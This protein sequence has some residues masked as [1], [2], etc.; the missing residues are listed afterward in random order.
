MKI[1]KDKTKSWSIFLSFILLFILSIKPAFGQIVIKEDSVSIPTYLVGKPDPM[2]RFYEHANHQGVQR[3][4]YPYP[5]NDNLTN[6][7]KDKK[8]FIISISNKYI[9]V[10]ISPE[11]GGR[12]FYA[13]DKSNGY[14]WIYR[15]H[16]IK[17]SLIGMEGWWISGGLSWG[18]PHHH[19]P[20]IC[21]PMNYK[22][23]NNPDSSVTVWFDNIDELARMRALVGYTIYPNS[24][25]I[26]MS[27]RLWNKTAITN[28]FLFWTVP[29]VHADTNYQVIFPPS[30]QY[31]TFHGKSWMTT[32]PIADGMFNGYDFKETD[33][34][35]WKN[36]YIPSSFFAWDE[37]ENYFGG[38]NHGLKAGTV[39][40]G[41]HYTQPGMKY[42]AD[43]NN[44]AGRSINSR[45][46]DDD[47][48]YIEQMSGVFTDN[49]PD[50]S[51]LQPY[52]TKNES[53]IWFPIRD[54]DGLKYANND[55]ALNLELSEKNIVKIRMNTASPFNQA[56]VVLKSKGQTI[57]EKD[58]NVS[59]AN[60]YKV[61]VP[62]KAG[63][64]EDDLNITL[65][66]A[67]GNS[68]LSYSPAE[69]HPPQYAK[70]E[71]NKHSLRPEEIKTVE[72]LYMEGLW[73]YQFHSINDPV[74]YF[75]EALKRDPGNY[76][77][78][79][80]LGIMDIQNFKWDEAASHLRKA[81]DRA[82]AHYMRPRD[83]ETVYYLGVV[84]K[85]KGQIDS[86]Y[87]CFYNAIWSYA[88]AAA[89]YLQL[90]QIDCMRG[91][92]DTALDHVNRSL[93]TNTNNVDAINLKTVILRKLNKVSEAKEVAL[94]SLKSDCL[95]RQALNELSVLYANDNAVEASKYMNEFTRIMI[96]SV[97]SYLELATDYAQ[98]G[99]YKDAISVLSIIE[100]K[101]NN[102]PMLYYYLGYYSS[103]VGDQNKAL[104]YYQVASTKP[105]LY[106]F[107][108]R[109]ESIEV[110][111]SV[112]QMN[113]K[114]AKAPYYLGNLLYEHQ[115]ENAIKE[116]EKSRQLDD[117]F[118]IVHRNLGVAYQEVQN[119]Y[120]KALA[121]MEKAVGCNVEN[122]RLLFEID[123][124]NALN[125]VEPTKAYEL[126]K[127][128]INT[129]KQRSET[130][131]SLAV[132]AIQSGKY[133]EA[134]NILKNNFIE[135]SEGAREKQDTYINAHTLRAMEYFN[136][137]K[138]KDALNDLDSALAY[139][140]GNYGRS[141]YAQLYYL[142][143]IV[144]EKIGETKK[145]KE[146]FQK[147][148]GTDVESR[149]FDS[150]F[151]YYR[152][153]ALQKL[154]KPDEA[155]KLFTDMLK[156]AQDRSGDRFYTGQFSRRGS[157]QGEIAANHYLIG[158][159]HEGLGEKE[160]AKEE[161]KHALKFDPGHVWS[162]QH[163]STL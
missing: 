30:V 117:S 1:V 40:V 52:E 101:G 16:V 74:P 14:D 44:P 110:L 20:N 105:Y 142:D 147:A 89:G 161:F 143:G 34:S 7:K 156:D 148:L 58:I 79:T 9:D 103:K 11:I 102:F 106:C 160:E 8:Y 118:Y 157:R 124:L 120:V 154:G 107:P 35:M 43:G 83:G 149:G 42:W 64:N 127:Q 23:E 27:I 88:W 77:V 81:I 62:V 119:D 33:I 76:K 70:P 139:P 53:M 82:T 71:V 140:I 6:I 32:W 112:M 136:N 54:M 134:L 85:A 57:F 138:Y 131:L 95:N 3:R 153:M 86:A 130:I 75:E 72:E 123:Q 111:K 24:S 93:S 46:T 69:H 158:L 108:F 129:V 25:K 31:I 68:L 97:Q 4:I 122:P 78:N 80:Q 144:Y 66:D 51:W 38:Y 104:S 29:A 49:Q 94:N 116:W 145:A 133:T 162:K 87:D 41:N 13:I 2:P 47:G 39:W 121:S 73:M 50:Y 22:I 151:L 48:Q 91:N 12:I 128:H 63:L 65:Y 26:K 37:K 21:Q 28:S 146:F 84:S 152:G 132:R 159:A 125:K 155:K 114:D 60:P 55:G 98:S 92:F 109:S 90:A 61:D 67:N 56:K 96:D 137:G 113:P 18:F 45:L 17:P 126:L 19:G 99:F 115:P 36:T 59:P 141:L 100:K 150:E 135:E 163:L 10:G 5:F 15:Q